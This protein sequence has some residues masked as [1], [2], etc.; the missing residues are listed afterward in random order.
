ML[1][2]STRRKACRGK[3]YGCCVAGSR[4][5]TVRSLKRSGS[6]IPRSN[7]LYHRAK[8]RWETENQG[9]NGAKNRHDLEHIV[10]IT[11]T[12]C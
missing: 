11:P 10:I 6:R 12:V 4:N 3:P 5:L 8:S 9:F 7:V 2:T 1:K